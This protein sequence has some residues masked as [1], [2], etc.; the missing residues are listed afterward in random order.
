MELMDLLKS[1]FKDIS[2]Y[3][4]SSAKRGHLWAVF[5]KLSVEELPRLWNNLF[6]LLQVNCREPLF[7]QTVNLILF[8]ELLK[9]DAASKDKRSSTVCD[10]QRIS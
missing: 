4:S 6:V 1:C 2:K 10:V 5:H 8:E 9:D 7:Y 3:R